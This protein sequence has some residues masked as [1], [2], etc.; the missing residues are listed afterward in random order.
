[1]AGPSGHPTDE[2]QV[3]EDPQN[4][5]RQHDLAAKLTVNASVRSTA[6]PIA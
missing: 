3:L 6:M 4:R 1:M 2:P 5:Q